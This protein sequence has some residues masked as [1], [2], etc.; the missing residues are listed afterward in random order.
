M[1]TTFVCVCVRLK[2]V[3]RIMQDCW[4]HQ[5]RT[6]NRK[7]FVKIKCTWSLCWQFTGLLHDFVWWFVHKVKVSDKASWVLDAPRYQTAVRWSEHVYNFRFFQV[8]VSMKSCFIRFEVTSLVRRRSMNHNSG[9]G[10]RWFKAQGEF[11]VSMGGSRIPQQGRGHVGR[12]GR[13]AR[14]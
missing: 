8:A 4:C 14:P 12:S 11:L 13:S 1:Q 5:G 7:M 6:V 10:V 2:Y 9:S 3:I